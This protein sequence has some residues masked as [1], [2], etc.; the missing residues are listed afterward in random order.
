MPVG[1][2][3]MAVHATPK[4]MQLAIGAL[5]RWLNERAPQLSKRIILFFVPWKPPLRSHIGFFAWPLVHQ[6]SRCRG[7]GLTLKPVRSVI[8]S[9]VPCA[10]IDLTLLVQQISESHARRQRPLLKVPCVHGS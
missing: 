4:V 7:F 1:Y 5:S 8:T 10:A 6:D 3:K 9:R 2:G